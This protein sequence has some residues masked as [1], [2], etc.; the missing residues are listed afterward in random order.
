M[1]KTIVILMGLQASGKTTFYKKYL[2]Q[3]LVHVNLDTLK[4]RKK[5]SETFNDCI[6]KQTS[7]AVDNTNPSRE[8]RARYI[9]PAKNAVYNVIGCFFQ[10]KIKDCIQRNALRE[11]KACVPELAIASTSNKLEIIYKTCWQIISH[12]I[13]SK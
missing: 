4:S 10:S 13:F 2:S 8:D 12:E 6:R 11:G 3:K 7:F 9:I 1:A 5:E